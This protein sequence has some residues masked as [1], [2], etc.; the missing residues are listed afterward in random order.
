MFSLKTHAN[1]KIYIMKSNTIHIMSCFLNS[2]I[3]YST[4]YKYTT[5]FISCGERYLVPPRCLYGFCTLSF[6]MGS[7]SVHRF[8]PARYIFCNRSCIM[9]NVNCSSRSPFTGFVLGL[10]LWL[11]MKL[12]VIMMQYTFLVVNGKH[13][14]H[15]RTSKDNLK[16]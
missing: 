16:I 9:I 15:S 14:N 11:T 1:L 4:M 5:L 13:T 8:S 12:L 10:I 2:L 3:L 7:N 6:L